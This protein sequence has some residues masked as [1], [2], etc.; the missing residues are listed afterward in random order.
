[1]VS[2]GAIC[3]FVLIANLNLIY[4]ILVLDKGEIR[5]FDRPNNLLGDQSY[6]FYNMA[7]DAGLS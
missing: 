4:R 5:E 2:E 1:M 6:L 3:A 7:K